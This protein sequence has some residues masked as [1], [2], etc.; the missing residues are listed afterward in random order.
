MRTVSI[1][2]MRKFNLKIHPEYESGCTFG[3]HIL[4]PNCLKLISVSSV[5]MSDRHEV[6]ATFDTLDTILGTR[7]STGMYRTVTIIFRTKMSR[8]R[9]EWSTNGSKGF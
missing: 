6:L 2:G 9:I 3:A 7:N 5:R 1:N 4:V 8:L